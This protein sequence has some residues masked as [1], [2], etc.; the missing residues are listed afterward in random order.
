M[1][2][3]VIKPAAVLV[4][5][6]DGKNVRLSLGDTQELPKSKHVETLVRL[7]VLE[8]VETPET[9]AAPKPSRKE[10]KAVESDLSTNTK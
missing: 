8:L 2:Y 5:N 7:G 1:E 4:K 6:A 10:A 9:P 3:K